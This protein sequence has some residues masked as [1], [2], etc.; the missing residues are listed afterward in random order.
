MSNKVVLTLYTSIC[1]VPTSEALSGLEGLRQLQQYFLQEGLKINPVRYTE[2][3]DVEKYVKKKGFLKSAS[4]KMYCIRLLEPTLTMLR[5]FHNILILDISW[6]VP[7]NYHCRQYQQSQG[8]SCSQLDSKT[9][10]GCLNFLSIISHS[11]L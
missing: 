3:S 2:N 8:M 11:I 7:Y 4:K 6:Y 10:F 1:S 9:L 5:H